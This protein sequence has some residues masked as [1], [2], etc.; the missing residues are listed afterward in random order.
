MWLNAIENK[1]RPEA[2][3]ITMG[4]W[5]KP[6]LSLSSAGTDLDADTVA[7]NSAKEF[8]RGVKHLGKKVKNFF[9][10][11]Y[12][13][14]SSVIFIYD[15]AGSRAM[16]GKAQFMEIEINIDTVNYIDDNE[17]PA[18]NLTTGKVEHMNFTDFVKAAQKS[19]N[20]ILATDEIKKQ[21]LVTFHKTKA[22]K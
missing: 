9:D 2:L 19:V 5:V 21:K 10:S 13:D 16:P 11:L 22:A 6:Q 8:E 17:N 4:V 14:P 12:F 7:I 15:F 20:S 1:K 3:F 18:P